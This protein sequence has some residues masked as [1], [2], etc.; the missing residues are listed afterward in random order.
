[1]SRVP[2]Q[3]WRLLQNSGS[4]AQLGEHLRCIQEVI[5]SNPITSTKYMGEYPNVKG[6]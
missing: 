1:M 2:L 6:T 3:K 5:G 4:V